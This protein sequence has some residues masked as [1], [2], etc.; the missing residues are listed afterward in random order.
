MDL[1]TPELRAVLPKLY[2]QD[3]NRNPTVFAK[4]FFP[5]GHW[6]WFATEGEPDGDDFRFYGYV[7]GHENEWGYFM[8]SELESLKLRG[9]T[10]ERDLYFKQAPFKEAIKGFG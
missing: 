4:F 3:G 8:L 5:A 10:V 7:I 9:L 1:L 2:S 6:T